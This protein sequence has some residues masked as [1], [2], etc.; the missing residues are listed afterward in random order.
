M[1][2]QKFIIDPDLGDLEEMLAHVQTQ[3]EH[4]I[5]LEKESKMPSLTNVQESPKMAKRTSSFN[6]GELEFRR[7]AQRPPIVR[8]SNVNSGSQSLNGDYRNGEY[9]HANVEYTSLRGSQTSLQSDDQASLKSFRSEPVQRHSVVSLQDKRGS[10]VSW[11][12]RGK[13][14]TLPRGYGSTKEKNWEEYWA[15]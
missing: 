9:A 14:S 8:M 15:Q 7:S 2:R 1:R 4:E 11:N 10:N 5:D 12:G 3:L 6:R 13:T